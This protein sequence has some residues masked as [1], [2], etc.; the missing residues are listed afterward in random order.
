MIWF[1]VSK[2]PFYFALG[3]KKVTRNTNLYQNLADKRVIFCDETL[4]LIFEGKDKVG[5]LE[6][7]KLLSP[8]FVKTARGGESPLSPIK[9]L[10]ILQKIGKHL[11]PG[12]EEDAHEF[13]RSIFLQRRVTLF[14]HKNARC[15]VETMQ[16]V[17]L[18]EAHAAGLFVE[19]TTLV[20]VTF[21]GYL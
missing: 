20:G 17:F 4:K 19:E 16:S 5:F 2:Y 7:S 14:F 10:S 15:A 1:Q 11:G 18:K 13:L 8:Y 6:I 21:G 9:I 12:K 3:T